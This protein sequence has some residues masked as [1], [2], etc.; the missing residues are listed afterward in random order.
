MEEKEVSKI[1][2]ETLLEMLK[3]VYGRLNLGKNIISDKENF[4]FYQQQ[5]INL[6]LK[7]NGGLSEQESREILEREFGKKFEDYPDREKEECAEEVSVS[8]I[9]FIA[10]KQENKATEEVVQFLLKHHSI[11]SIKQDSVNEIW[12]YQ[13]GVYKPN[14]ESH[15][16]ELCRLLFKDAFTPQRANK[17]IAKIQ[18]DTFIEANDFFL[19]E[20]ANIN[21]IPC[22]NGILNIETFK[23]HPFTPD[24][25]FF[26]KINALYDPSVDCPIIKKFFE[27][28]LKDPADIE[29]IFE[30]IGTMLRKKYFPQKAVMFLGN[31]ENGKGITES[32][33]K[34]FLGAEN[35]S[36][37]P[38][39]QM[40]SDSFSV[41]EMFGKLANLAGDISNTDL[42]DTGRFKE[43]S[44]GTDMVSAHRKFKQD[45]RFVN[46]AK[47]VFSCNE[48]PRSYDLTHGFWRRWVLLEF[49]YTFLNRKEYDLAQDKTNIKLADS[50]IFSKIT[51]QK[52]LS[53][54][55]NEALKGLKRVLQNKQ[56]TYTK[57][58]SDIMDFWIRKSD[59]FTAFCFDCLEEDPQGIIPKKEIRKAFGRY[60]RELKLKGASDQNIKVVLENMFGVFESRRTFEGNFDPV[61]EGIKF[62]ESITTIKDINGFSPYSKNI[63]LHI[64]SKRV[65]NLDIDK[66]EDKKCAYCGNNRTSITQ[67]GINYYC[68]D[69][70]AKQ[71][72]SNNWNSKKEEKAILIC[73]YYSKCEH[74]GKRDCTTCP[75]FKPIGDSHD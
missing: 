64:G 7:H 8:A 28:V 49:P 1:T 45:L 35:C 29:V 3:G 60:C 42:K 72:W 33:I 63:N 15:I 11:Y 12:F 34:T 50:D 71:N 67:D 73:A 16:K 59:S 65:D 48:L 2:K 55:L 22:A 57:S 74:K 23:L 4:L 66:K 58:T 18:A 69:C 5:L 9:K 61:W 10:M 26:N 20:Q 43:L 39:N 47:M 14:G 25:I 31:G 19:Q 24:K 44:S 36:S 6:S 41:S 52:E 70:A 37:I 17:V 21:E 56:Y 27:D 13:D 30:I 38:L 75:N 68:E 51:T 32:L 46:Y 53:G 54:L 40:T 62:K